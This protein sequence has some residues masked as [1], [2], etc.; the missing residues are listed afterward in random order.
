[1]YIAWHW[2]RSNYRS[3]DGKRLSE[4]A[5]LVDTHYTVNQ[6]DVFNSH[7]DLFSSKTAPN[8]NELPTNL[9]EIE[10]KVQTT[11]E[12]PVNWKF[13]RTTLC[14]QKQEREYIDKLFQQG[15]IEPSCFDWSSPP[16]LVTK[17]SG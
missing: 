7:D 15:V 6:V 1:M 4:R 11:D 2:T 8:D 16:D 13:R 10:H 17:I 3:F 14:F 5:L 9:Q 12:I